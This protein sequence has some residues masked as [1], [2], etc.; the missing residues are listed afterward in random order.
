MTLAAV[1]RRGCELPH[2]A[3]RTPRCEARRFGEASPEERA[4]V[5]PALDTECDGADFLALAELEAV[6][7]AAL[8]ARR[9]RSRTTKRSRRW[10]KAATASEAPSHASNALKPGSSSDASPG[11]RHAVCALVA[12]PVP[13]HPKACYGPASPV[14]MTDSFFGYVST[15]WLLAACM[16]VQPLLPVFVCP[17]T[18]NSKS[19]S[20]SLVNVS[21][22]PCCMTE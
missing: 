4:T 14:Q 13:C 19:H 6:D 9:P 16:R 10:Q 7:Y 15:L 3:C 11:C 20:H 2:A 12:R 18:P 22:L 21:V 1:H 8:Q 17:T 5:N